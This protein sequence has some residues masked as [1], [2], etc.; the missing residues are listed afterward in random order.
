V[1]DAATRL[2]ELRD[3]I[4]HHDYQYYVLDAPEIED[5]AYD[6][7]YRELKVPGSGASGVGR[8][9]FAHPPGRRHGA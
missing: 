5:A 4:H 9:Q 7:L 3:L 8:S 6:A 2:R 1:S